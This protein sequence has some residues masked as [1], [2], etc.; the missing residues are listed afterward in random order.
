MQIYVQL[1]YLIRMHD[2]LEIQIAVLIY[3]QRS[4]DKLLFLWLAS[5]QTV[6]YRFKWASNQFPEWSNAAQ[7]QPQFPPTSFLL[8]NRFSKK[9]WQGKCVISVYPGGDD[10]NLEE[11][12]TSGWYMSENVWIQ[13]FLLANVLSS[14]LNINW[15]ILAT[16]GGIYRFER[17]FSKYS[18]E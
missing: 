1:I 2:L 14:D 9:H 15:K 12:F 11:N 13:F 5:G 6:M 18:G 3:I 10:K 4:L 17:N 8:R 16:R 7:R